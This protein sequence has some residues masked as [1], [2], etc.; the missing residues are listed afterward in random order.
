M[1]VKTKENCCDQII[2]SI[3]LQL[4]KDREVPDLR[5]CNCRYAFLCIHVTKSSYALNGVDEAKLF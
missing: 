4:Y 1:S 5:L 3:G 2:E